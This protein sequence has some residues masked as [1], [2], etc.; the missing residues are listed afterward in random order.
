VECIFLCPAFLLLALHYRFVQ[1][2]SFVPVYCSLLEELSDVSYTYT[3]KIVH[4][5]LPEI[6]PVNKAQS[7]PS[8]SPSSSS[9]SSLSAIFRLPPEHSATS[10]PSRFVPL[11]SFYCSLLCF[12]WNLLCFRPRNRLFHLFLFF[13][14]V[15]IRLSPSCAS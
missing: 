14:L 2:D 10:N 5:L 6:H 9:S 11:T 7:S 1:L 8:K 15:I 4:L 3:Y 13:R 12:D